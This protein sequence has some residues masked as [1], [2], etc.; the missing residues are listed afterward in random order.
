[1]VSRQLGRSRGGQIFAKLGFWVGHL[2]VTSSLIALQGPENLQVCSPGG[3][4]GPL[5]PLN[6]TEQPLYYTI[7]KR[8]TIIPSRPP[9][10]R[11][12]ESGTNP[13]TDITK[14]PGAPE[15]DHFLDRTGR[16]DHL[17]KLLI[18]TRIL[19][20]VSHAVFQYGPDQTRQ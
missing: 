5:A 18:S 17:F 1:M 20:A 2:K 12:F 19:A 10:K 15:S 16:G 13:Q 9:P 3:V 6:T 7:R 14:R 11:R 4:L 8:R